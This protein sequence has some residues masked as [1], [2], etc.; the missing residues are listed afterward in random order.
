VAQRTLLAVTAVLFVVAP[1]PSLRVSAAPTPDDAPTAADVRFLPA[2]VAETELPRGDRFN[3]ADLALSIVPPAGWVQ[4]PVTAL[5]P[6]SD[7]PEPVQE[8]ARFQIRVQDARLYATPIPITSGLVADA[9]ALISIGVARMGSDV[10]DLERRGRVARE[11]GSVAG[12]TFLDD[13]ATYEGLHVLTRYLFSRETDRVLVLRAAAPET[14]WTGLEATL[15]A[16]IASFTGD[17]RGANAPAPPPPPPPAP[18]PVTAEPAPDP[19]AFIRERILERAATLLGLRYVWGGNS[20]TAGMDCSAYVSWVWSVSRYTTDSIW[21]VSF[22]IT[23]EALRAG[24]A[25]NLTIGRDPAR[26]GHIRIF[27][28]WANSEHTAMWVYEETP[29]RVVHRVIAYDDRYQPIRLAGLSSAGE[30]RLIPGTPAPSTRAT[31]VATRRPVATAVRTPTPSN[32][33]LASPTRTPV[34]TPVPTRTPT[35]APTRTPIPPEE[36]N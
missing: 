11:L 12:F 18:A 30:A 10:L 24:D 3:D 8:A 25:M 31:P 26:K 2:E 33:R 1:L 20:T 19:T 5:N 15:R 6:Q 4:S 23:K 34:P 32:R 16:S 27:E 21:N 13:E 17:P 28:A 35:P 22:P 29:P 9:G 36:R 7:P 14:S